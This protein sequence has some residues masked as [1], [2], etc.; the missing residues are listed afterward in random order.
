MKYMILVQVTETQTVTFK[1][2]LCKANFQKKED[3]ML[4]VTG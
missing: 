1:F 3:A 4:Q 2:N